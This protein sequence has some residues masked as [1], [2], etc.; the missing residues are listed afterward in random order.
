MEKW[1][2]AGDITH[3][4]RYLRKNA[5]A[6]SSSAVSVV[7][8][9]STGKGSTIAINLRCE[10]E[11]QVMSYSKD[12]SF[13]QVLGGWRVAVNSQ[14]KDHHALVLTC[15]D[16]ALKFM[17]RVKSLRLPSGESKLLRIRIRSEIPPACGL[18]SSSA[19][20]TAVVSSIFRTFLKG[21]PDSKDVLDVSCK[22]SIDAGASIT[23]AYDDASACLLGGL[24][25]TDNA[26]FTLLEHRQVPESLGNIVLL[27]VPPR[28]RR[29]FTSSVDQSAYANFRSQSA[30][31]FHYALKGDLPQA[32]FLNSVVQSLALKYSIRPVVDAILEGS[33]AS[34]IS[35]KGPA[36]FAFCQSEKSARRITSS[37]QEDR[38]NLRM[39]IIKTHVVQPK[40]GH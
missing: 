39:Q 17:S 19:V 25:L 38:R 2:G 14:D 18:K 32:I 27:L 34:G 21:E 22:A 7:N 36:M 1:E 29:K 40:R 9:L 16:R 30:E 23:G 24:V 8:A 37:W 6:E 12:K 35:G 28:I 5:R 20:S 11:T 13:G 4:M 3:S 31:A 33:T 15:I 10:V 26:K